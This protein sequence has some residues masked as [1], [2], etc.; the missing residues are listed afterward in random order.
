MNSKTIFVFSFTLAVSI[1][2]AIVVADMNPSLAQSSERP[3]KPTGLTVENVGFGVLLEWDDPRDPSITGYRIWRR[4]VRTKH[5]T[6]ASTPI[7]SDLRLIVDHTGSAEN[8]F[9]D[10]EGL[11]ELTTYAYGINAI[12]SNVGSSGVSDEVEITRPALGP[13]PPDVVTG[14]RAKYSRGHIEIT[15]DRVTDSSVTDSSV[16]DIFIERTLPGRQDGGHFVHVTSEAA[17]ATTYTSFKD[18]TNL[19]PRTTYFYTIRAKNDVGV[20]PRSEPVSVTT[21]MRF[22]PVP[23]VRPKTPLNIKAETIFADGHHRVIVTWDRPRERDQVTEWQIRQLNPRSGRVLDHF[24]VPN[25]YPT[26]RT[27]HDTDV[28]PSTT[29]SYTVAA[30][31]ARGWSDVSRRVTVTTGGETEDLRFKPIS[32]EE[33]FETRMPDTGGVAPKP[34]ILIL[35]ALFGLV[36]IPTG[37]ALRTRMSSRDSSGFRTPRK[38]R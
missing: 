32:I 8:H 25:E 23:T 14:L 34:V 18:S 3:T 26:L 36:A 11:E 19:E 4:I 9:F 12:H 31:N 15:W 2:A 10:S 27:F 28:L 35:V 38:W 30:V 17:P 7:V 6:A 37:L 13:Q 21:P 22:L 16:T 29:Y 5:G 24:E 20:G 1:V 33:W